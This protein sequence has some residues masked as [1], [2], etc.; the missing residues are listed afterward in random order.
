MKKFGTKIGISGHG[1]RIAKNVVLYRLLFILN[2]KVDTPKP[3]L[4]VLRIQGLILFGRAKEAFYVKIGDFS[5]E[6]K[7]F[8]KL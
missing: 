4:C 2:I 6:T 8:L 1:M 7:E 5:L 3:P